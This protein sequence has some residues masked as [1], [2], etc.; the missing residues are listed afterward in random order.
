MVGRFD[1][2]AWAIDPALLA[3]HLERIV[4]PTVCISYQN[5]M[6]ASWVLLEVNSVH[7]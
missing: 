3:S 7:V 6:S 1:G 5:N 2:D 4:G